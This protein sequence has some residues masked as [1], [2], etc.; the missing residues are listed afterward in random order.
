MR[1]HIRNSIIIPT[2]MARRFSKQL[3][4][5]MSGKRFAELNEAH[6]QY[7]ATTPDGRH[8]D[9]VTRV[10][11]IVDRRAVERHLISLCDWNNKRKRA[12]KNHDSA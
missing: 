7:V 9:L 5:V 10:Q 4:P 6:D 1:A 3:F 11:E 8:Y 2:Q 12:M